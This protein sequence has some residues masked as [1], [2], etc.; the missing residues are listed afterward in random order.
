MP[1]IPTLSSN[2]WR[3]FVRALQL[4]Y[5]SIEGMQA[6]VILEL[7]CCQEVLIP[8]QTLHRDCAEG[9]QWLA[10]ICALT[11]L[12]E[13]TLVS[14]EDLLQAWLPTVASWSDYDAAL[15]PKP[16][17]IKIKDIYPS[18]LLLDTKRTLALLDCLMVCAEEKD[19]G[20]SAEPCRIMWI[21]ITWWG[22]GEGGGA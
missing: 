12:A 5:E 15:V 11:S 13:S 22:L 3:A 16:M 10:L 17:A 4:K 9:S 6:E 18:F 14:G 8:L 20:L 2:L 19:L 7:Q 21:H 1:V